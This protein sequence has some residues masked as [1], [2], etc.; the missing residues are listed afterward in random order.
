MQCL[1]KHACT[2]ID[3][4]NHGCAALATEV[5]LEESSQLTLT[6]R[7]NSGMIPKRTMTKYLTN[8][9]VT[10][11]LVYIHSCWH[12]TAYFLVPQFNIGELSNF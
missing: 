5:T 11:L 4:D 12:S 2:L 6:E 8:I 9:I 7:H 10:Q 3:V 1:V